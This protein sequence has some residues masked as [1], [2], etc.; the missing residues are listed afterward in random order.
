MAEVV[1]V[2]DDDKEEEDDMSPTGEA[3][4]LESTKVFTPSDVGE[5]A[6]NGGLETFWRVIK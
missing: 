3:A 4:L 2:E 6:P 5:R 1:V